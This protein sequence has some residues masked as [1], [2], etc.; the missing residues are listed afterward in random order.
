MSRSI[1]KNAAFMTVASVGQKIIA[2][3]YFT[4][5]ARNIGVESTGKYFFA[6]SF[7][8]IF[9]IFVDLGLTNVL[10]R[11]AAKMKEKIQ[12]YFSTIIS[13]KILLGILSYIGAVLAI[14]LM[15]YPVETKQL[16]YLSAVTMLFDS[17]HLTIYGT[18]RAIG[19][20][21]YEAISIVGSQL[22]TLVLGSIFLYEGLPLI[23]LILAFTIPSFLN[24]L[25]AIFIAYNKYKIRFIPYFDKKVFVYLGK[26]TIPFAIAA[27]FARFYSYIDSILLSKMAGDAAVGWY[28]IPY[29]ITYAFQFIP[30]ALVA[31]LYPRFSQYFSEDKEK[32]AYIFERGMK[33]LL[34][35]AFPIAVGIGLIAGDIILLL[36]GKE[37]IN[38]ILPL[39][40]LVSS[41]IFSFVSFPIGAFLNACNK[42]VTQT[43]IVGIVLVVNV[44]LN[45]LL[46]PRF[47]V[48]GASIAALVGNIVLTLLGYIM[49]PMVTKISHSFIFKALFQIVISVSVMG[50]F[51]W[52]INGLANFTIAI[53]AG[54][55]VYPVMLFVTRAVTR[56]QLAEALALVRR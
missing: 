15:G 4:L 48:V 20:L 3:V 16:V 19:D 49:V 29:K 32:L 51:V 54:V 26:I 9:V 17:L 28:S 33:Y 14:N 34:I 2:F 24:V 50:V 5:I 25:F 52:F 6:I 21:K 40:I 45:I 38:S 42:Q 23:Y 18:L 43:T 37:Y 56:E 55:V 27:V 13:V 31:A 11:E 7:T 22:V 46:I 36:Y 35:I 8:T 53:L 41:L 47:N 12:T 10:I 30:L 1:A 39:K 44:V